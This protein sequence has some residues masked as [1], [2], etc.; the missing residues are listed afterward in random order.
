[1]W[2][3]PIG[4]IP[5]LPSSPATKKQSRLPLDSRHKCVK[6]IVSLSCMAGTEGG[7]KG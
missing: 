3:E 6:T 1:M 7:G 5:F 4:N 2:V